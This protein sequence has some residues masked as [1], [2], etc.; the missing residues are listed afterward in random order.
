MGEARVASV[1]IK[2]Y[3]SMT[4]R[5]H[6][7]ETR[8]EGKAAIYCCGMTPYNYAHIGNMRT[9]VW[10]DMIRRYLVYRGYDV[11]FVMNYTDVDDKIIE[12]AR[13]EDITPEEVTAK[14]EAAFEEDLKGAGAQAP[15]HLPRATEHIQGMIEAIEGLVEKGFAYPAEGNVWFSV[16]SFPGYGKLSGRTLED[17]RAGERVEPH[18]G[19]R[20]PLDFSLWKAAKEGEPAWES[21]WGLGRPGWH[22]ECSVMSDKLLGMGFEIHGG[23]SDLIFPHHE[24]EIAQSEALAGT[25]PFA[26]YWLHAGMVQMED[27]KMSKSLGNV[28]LAREVL[29]RYSKDAVRY[30]MLQATYRSQLSF[31]GTALED[32]VQSFGRWK[33]FFDSIRHALGE[34]PPPA[35][36]AR[37]GTGQATGAGAPF[38]DAFVEA[39][40]ED[41][42]SAEAFATIH[43]L[44]RQGNKLLAELAD[45]PSVREDLVSVA[46]AFAELTGVFG[47]SFEDEGIDSALVG[48]LLDYLLERRERARQRKDFEEADEIRAKLTELG[49]VI[50]DTPTGARWRIGDA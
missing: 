5:L 19:K 32:A 35:A 45:N 28:A 11:T 44:V 7:F 49:V 43:D 42:N 13:I 36:T 10:F 6:P 16:E 41:F 26:R 12:R 2:V 39:M 47:F 38:I 23:G 24:N 17:M 33:T 48:G 14:Y 8:E 15:D 37:T 21:P 3:D 50:E 1:T 22:I 18:P 27:E 20:H 34:V 31:S 9:F 40:D 29:E 46:A 4:R 30:W 25:E